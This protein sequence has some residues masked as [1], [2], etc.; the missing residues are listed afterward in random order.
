[1]KRQP[2]RRKVKRVGQ[3]AVI[4]LAASALL[5]AMKP[6]H[7][8]ER[9]LAQAADG[10]AKS[11][12]KAKAEKK[13]KPPTRSKKPGGKRPVKNPFPDRIRAPS[14]D[15]GVAWLNTDGEISL[16][17]L[18]GKVV[19]LDFWTYCCINCMHVL[20]DLAYLEKKYPKE[21]VV[22]GVHSAKFANEKETGNIRKAIVRY[23]IEHP[24]LNDPN[25]IVW[26]KYGTQSWPTLAL[27]DPEGYY[28]GSQ[29][30][31]GNR[32]LF[33]LVIA[34]LIEYH[35]AKGTLDTTP[36]RFKLE[37]HGRKP[38]PLKFPGK[39]L[40]DAAGRRLFISDSN[41]NRIVV[42][43]LDGKLLDVIG[44]GG[45]GAD[46]GG[47]AEATFDHPQG[48][49][50]VGEMLYVAD[51]E[52]HKLRVVDLKKRQVS[53]LAGTG[54]QARFRAPG[55]ALNKTPLNSPWALGHV[56]GVLYVAMAGPHQLWS[57]KLGSDLIRV[58]AGSGR[59][60]I[61]NG[62]LANAAM[63][64]PSAIATDGKFLYIA[65][66]EGSAI[67]Q[68]PTDPAG[69]MT[70]LVGPSDLVGGRS[71]FEFG[72]ID[73]VGSKARLQHPLGV[74]WHNGTLYVADS[75]NHKIKTVDLKT[76][77]CET[78]LG[79]G[80]P[81]TAIQPPRLSE[82]AGVSIA[83]GRLYIADTNNHRI[84]VADLK[85]AR[86]R[87]LVIEGLNP[88]AARP[89]AARDFVG[90]GKSVKVPKQTVAAGGPVVFRVPLTMTGDFKLNPRAAVAYRVTADRG[91]SLVA[92]EQLNKRARAT[93]AESHAVVRL[94]LTGQIGTAT[95]ELVVSYQI[96]R[97]GKG[98]LCKLK[99]AAYRIPLTTSGDSSTTTI[100]LP[101]GK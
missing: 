100:T 32:E 95:L 87:E 61:A 58:Y 78:W 85:S 9:T 48:T 14:L 22:I 89:E 74:A 96:C 64:Q 80:K 20:P 65:D 4:L 68:V 45:I 38:T 13:K 25:M 31:E 70:T 21:L 46:D 84:L 23:E 35:K 93:V 6:F 8:G 59:E 2:D 66:S 18:R 10:T 81:G 36:V 92:E 83:A 90:V 77:R 82:P 3:V 98:G 69:E 60:D 30:G 15:G 101:A 42:V 1:M 17:D 67:R 57:H 86:T 75:Y 40:A 43:S 44:T 97:D 11:K 63:A 27:I 99:T 88:P 41:H 55:G 94:P 7:R 54:V 51:T 53:T 76:R 28:V 71:L 16:K 34:K 49:V 39:V 26:R 52:N 56:G 12:P 47:Y 19:V 29:G 62:P 37:R 73:A 24:V 50:L 5:V 72:D 79:N 33:D 91:Q